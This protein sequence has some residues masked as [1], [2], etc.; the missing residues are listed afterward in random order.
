M[1]NPHLIRRKPIIEVGQTKPTGQKIGRPR[2]T[3]SPTR[4]GSGSRFPN[5][6]TNPPLNFGTLCRPRIS[7]GSWCP[8]PETVMPESIRVPPEK[9]PGPSLLANLSV[10]DVVRV[11]S[12]SRTVRWGKYPI[13]G[14]NPIRMVVFKLLKLDYLHH[15][16]IMGLVEIP[17]GLLFS[18]FEYPERGGGVLN[19]ANYGQKPGGGA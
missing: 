9:L 12:S 5:H 17:K 13:Q 7:Q 18:F 16:S 15:L 2:K 8:P 6:A 19:L 10:Y 14:P 3:A 1:K 4:W 11:P